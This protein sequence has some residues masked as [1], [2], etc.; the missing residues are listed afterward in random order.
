MLK[1]DG[2]VFKTAIS[3][4]FDPH[5]TLD[6]EEIIYNCFDRSGVCNAGTGKEDNC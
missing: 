6:D 4:T 1:E 3:I 5:F 2:R